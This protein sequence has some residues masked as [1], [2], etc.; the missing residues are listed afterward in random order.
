M[1]ELN[2]RIISCY[3]GWKALALRDAGEEGANRVLIDD[4]APESPPTVFASR[5]DVAREL[6]A[7][8]ELTALWKEA[9]LGLSRYSRAKLT[10][11]RA[12][13]SQTP[14]E[15]VSRAAVAARG[16][17]WREVTDSRLSAH[18][19]RLSSMRRA[20]AEADFSLDSQREY[21]D[22]RLAQEAVIPAI[23]G[24]AETWLG[25]LHIRFPS[26]V[27]AP[28]RLEA[29]QSLAAWRNRVTHDGREFVLLVNLAP[30][31]V[32]TRSLTEVLALHEVCG[33]VVHLQQLAAS[34][35]I[36]DVHPELL[37]FSIHTHDSYYLEGVAQFVSWMMAAP[38]GEAPSPL[39]AELLRSELLMLVRQRNIM[40]LLEGRIDVASAAARHRADFPDTPDAEGV[41]SRIVSDPFS[42]C[43][44][45]NYVSS[46]DDF[47]PALASTAVRAA[48]AVFTSSM[49]GFFDPQDVGR[50]CNSVRL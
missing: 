41:Y 47:R 9:P 27:P 29:R 48:E 20:M 23:R 49:D 1:G 50:L 5:V 39:A 19:E 33:H 16:T 17:P 34:P 45:L 7:L 42:A 18:R 22:Q 21:F 10:H 4:L 26:L 13:L 3:R 12:F 14:G 25:R 28:F 11:S 6:D 43:Q 40:D 36:R 8:L 24:S 46:L 37:C 32:Y 2:R 35:R 38:Q 31:V 15:R 44:T 30:H